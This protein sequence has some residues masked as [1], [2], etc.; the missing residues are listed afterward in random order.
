MPGI[1]DRTG[2]YNPR[3]LFSAAT[4]LELKIPRMLIAGGAGA[5]LLDMMVLKCL[6]NLFQK[7]IPV[8]L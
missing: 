1:G 6:E 7:K 3:S 4:R 8:L 5:A 2:R